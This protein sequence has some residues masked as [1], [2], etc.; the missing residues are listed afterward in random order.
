VTIIDI[1]LYIDTFHEGIQFML[2]SDSAQVENE[3]IAIVP[4]NEIETRINKIKETTNI[5]MK[6]L[7]S[8][9]FLLAILAGNTSAQLD[10]SQYQQTIAINDG[11]HLSYVV[12]VD[13]TSTGQ[14]TLSAELVYTGLGWVGLG[15]SESGQMVPSQAGSSYQAVIGLPGDNVY[16]YDMS[17]KSDAGVMKST[18][19]TLTNTAVEQNATH[20]SIRF[21]KALVE[22]NE[23]SINSGADNFFIWAYGSSNTLGYHASRGAVTVPLDPCINGNTAPVASPVSSGAPRDTGAPVTSA[24]AAAPVAS[25]PTTSE[26]TFAAQV[27]NGATGSLDCSGFQQELALATGVTFRYT[28][29]LDATDNTNGVMS[30]QLVYEGQAWIGVGPSSSVNGAMVPADAVIGLPG[31]GNSKSNPGKYTLT[32][33][34]ISGVTLLDD[35]RQTLANHKIEQNDTHTV[36]T[37]DKILIEA[38]EIPIVLDSE[39]AF[40]WAYGYGND[41]GVHRSRGAVR[42]AVGACI[43]GVTPVSGN[44]A[45][46]LSTPSNYKSFWSAHGFLAGI[47]W[48]ILSPLAIGSSLLRDLI[49]KAGLWFK[50]HMLLNMTVFVFTVVAFILAVVAQENGKIPGESASHFVGLTHRTVG[51]VI[52]IF[53]S[54]QVL[55]GMLRPHAPSKLANGKIEDKAPIRLMWEL[56]HK[57]SGYGL[58]VCGWWQVQS[59]LNLYA[60]RFGTKDLSPA[61]WGVVAAIAGIV[62]VLYFYSKC[63]KRKHVSS[64]ATV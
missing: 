23:L 30:A 10:C 55:G 63:L 34:D 19:Q 49:P 18:A 12:V 36:M 3:L 54:L 11:L 14:G 17:G 24:P 31:A 64:D 29:K 7:T 45:G 16:K 21:T 8:P 59:G 28:F 61:F 42:L 48:G 51:L 22:D 46:M 32:S 40:I 5:A 44:S 47:A 26:P 27:S 4:S 56:V 33:K 20:T 13:D 50:I 60:V 62:A 43:P 6:F 1:K 38:N 15:F 53:V 37:F 35:S 41:L 25:T 58:L 57:G 52:M 2:D 39:I 9:A